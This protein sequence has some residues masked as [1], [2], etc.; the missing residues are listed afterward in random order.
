MGQIDGQIA[1]SLTAPTSQGDA[2]SVSIT[3]DQRA[4]TWDSAAAPAV[5]AVKMCCIDSVWLVDGARTRIDAVRSLN[6]QPTTE[7]NES[8]T[9]KLVT[10]FIRNAC[11]AFA[12]SLDTHARTHACTH[13]RTHT[14]RK[15]KPIWILLK[16]ETASGSGISWAIC[17][18]APR[19]RQITMPVPHHSVFYRPDALPAAQPT[20]SKHWRLICW[21]KL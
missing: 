19:S 10:A 21:T 15:V 7:I 18:S 14:H 5:S 8:Y 13:A 11:W 4:C 16:Q 12:P 3:S 1:V 2:L 17:K 9:D 6:I 20:A